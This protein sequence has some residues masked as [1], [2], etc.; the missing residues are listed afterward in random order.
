MYCVMRTSAP[1][2]Y[3]VYRRYDRAPWSIA[4]NIKNLIRSSLVCELGGLE[5]VL[6]DAGI[7]AIPI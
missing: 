1:S 4:S 5:N 3:N 6:R 7:R 2:L